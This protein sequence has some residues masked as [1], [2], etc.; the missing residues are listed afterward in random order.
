MSDEF[1]KQE[2]I[3]YLGNIFCVKSD[4]TDT[5]YQ[6]VVA[7]EVGKIKS[8]DVWDGK[9]KLCLDIYGNYFSI[10]KSQFHDHIQ[11][12]KPEIISHQPSS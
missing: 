2:A 10:N 1:T 12:L 8:I 9:L 5:H 6:M 7:G 4:F 3:S 11:I